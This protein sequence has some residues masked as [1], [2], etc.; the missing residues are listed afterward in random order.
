[1]RK[2]PNSSRE[3]SKVCKIL[4]IVI[5]PKG[6]I[7]YPVIL[8]RSKKH[9]VK[10]NCQISLSDTLFT[11]FTLILFWIEGL[12][13]SI[14]GVC[15]D[16]RT[17]I[18]KCGHACRTYLSYIFTMLLVHKMLQPNPT[19]QNHYSSENLLSSLVICTVHTCVFMYLTTQS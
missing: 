11:F 8:R 16:R 15:R 2:Y 5:Q 18:N 4:S 3:T 10:Q 6:Y 12:C 1:M 19:R 14:F 9:V 13:M 7:T 17:W